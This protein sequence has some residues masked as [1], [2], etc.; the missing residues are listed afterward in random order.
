M[1]EEIE[2]QIYFQSLESLN[3]CDLYAFYFLPFDSGFAGDAGAILRLGRSPRI[4]SGNPLQFSCLEKSMDRGAWMA[5]VHEVTKSQ[6][7]VSM[8]E[9]RKPHL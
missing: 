2:S 3:L 5:T 1:V 4:G 9:K 6:T 8:H 7:Q